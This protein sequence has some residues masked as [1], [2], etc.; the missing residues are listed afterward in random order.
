VNLWRVAEVVTR[1]TRP[2]VKDNV[3]LVNC[4][5]RDM[6]RAKSDSTR[7]MQVFFALAR[8]YVQRRCLSFASSERGPA[9]AR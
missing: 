9:P 8:A 5:P 6:P 3:Q 4:V 7:L 1:L 2:L